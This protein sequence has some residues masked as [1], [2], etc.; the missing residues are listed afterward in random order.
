MRVDVE[1][2]AAV[3]QRPRGLVLVNAGANDGPKITRPPTPAQSH[4]PDGFDP[5]IMPILALHW[6]GFCEGDT[7]GWLEVA[8]R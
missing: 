5:D 6:F 7:P 1:T 3:C 4:Y 2:P 8:Q